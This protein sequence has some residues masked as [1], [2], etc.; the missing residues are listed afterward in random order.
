MLQESYSAATEYNSSRT[1]ASLR[2]FIIGKGMNVDFELAVI[3]L[4]IDF[5]VY[6]SVTSSQICGQLIKSTKFRVTEGSRN[7]STQSTW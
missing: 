5:V 1:G 2:F 3:P 4:L 7:C 6:M